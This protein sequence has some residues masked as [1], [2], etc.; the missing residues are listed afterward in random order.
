MGFYRIKFGALK[1][2]IGHAIYNPAIYFG[3][4]TK[5]QITIIIYSKK[6]I[7]HYESVEQ[8]LSSFV[9]QLSH[10]SPRPESS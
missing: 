8:C 4:I 6:K 2:S 5:N 1:E 3:D 10:I 9:H 7:H